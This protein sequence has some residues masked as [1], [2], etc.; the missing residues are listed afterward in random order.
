DG[1]EAILSELPQSDPCGSR[2]DGKDNKWSYDTV[3]KMWTAP[4]GTM[5]DAPPPKSLRK[6]GFQ[7]GNR[8]A[9]GGRVIYRKRMIKVAADACS[10]GLT[11][12]QI[13]DL[14]SVS[15]RTLRSWRNK[16]PLFSAA[17]KAGKKE[18]HNMV[19]RSLFQKAVGYEW[20]E[21]RIIQGHK[22]TVRQQIPP[23][24]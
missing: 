13:A 24:T 5:I 12:M 8:L 19:E 23:D 14:L 1:P 4:N 9:K 3:T 11:D 20:E 2:A 10:R 18:A 22:V 17:F 15:A 7:K 21:D 6:G 16:Y